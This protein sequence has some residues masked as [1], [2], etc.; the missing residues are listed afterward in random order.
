MSN[1]G[2]NDVLPFSCCYAVNAMTLATVPTGAMNAVVRAYGIAG[3]GNGNIFNLANGINGNNQMPRPPVGNRIADPA[4]FITSPSFQPSSSQVGDNPGFLGTIVETK[5][6]FVGRLQGA[7]LLKKLFKVEGDI[8]KT[9]RFPGG[10][11]VQEGGSNGNHFG[12]SSK[13]CY[14]SYVNYFNNLY[15]KDPKLAKKQMKKLMKLIK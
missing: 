12:G 5:D 2:G 6:A 15:K 11:L 8:L 14:D 10:T 4:A 7:D 9:P 13:L 1:E 3:A